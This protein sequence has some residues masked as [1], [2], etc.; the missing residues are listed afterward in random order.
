MQLFIPPLST[1]FFPPFLRQIKPPVT[2][3]VI[4]ESHIDV[5]DIST[6]IILAEI[7]PGRYNVIDGNHRVEKAYRTGADHIA[8]YKLKPRQHMPFLTSME[9]YHAYIEYWNSKI[10]GGHV[11][12]E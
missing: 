12:F 2:L 10:K 9:S 6:P 1:I 7:C 11:P 3:A 8:A 5:V 4:T